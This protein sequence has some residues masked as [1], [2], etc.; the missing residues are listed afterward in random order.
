MWEDIKVRVEDLAKGPAEWLAEWLAEQLEL[1]RA[2]GQ[3]LEEKKPK[4]LLG[5]EG[6]GLPREQALTAIRG[7]V[8]RDRD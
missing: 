1:T 6:G 5:A 7:P 3:G 2:K 4:G 8:R